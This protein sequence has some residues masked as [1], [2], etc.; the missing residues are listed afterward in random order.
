M[1]PLKLQTDGLSY[2]SSRVEIVLLEKG[3]KWEEVRV[4]LAKQEHKVGVQAYVAI[5]NN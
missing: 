1:A 4:N 5:Q 3:L 2:N